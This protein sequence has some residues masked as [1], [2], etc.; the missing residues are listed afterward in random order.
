MEKKYQ[1]EPIPED[2]EIPSAPVV[3]PVVQEVAVEQQPEPTPAPVVPEVSEPV[4][5][6][7]TPQI[8]QIQPAAPVVEPVIQE[9]VVEQQPEPTPEPVEVS[10]ENTLQTDI[11]KK[12]SELFFTTKKIYELKEKLNISTESFDIL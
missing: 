7:V 2:N 11:Q 8:P 12:F 1:F 3:E 10:W 5:K 6:P 9:V 4:T